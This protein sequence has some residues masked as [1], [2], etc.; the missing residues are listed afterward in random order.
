MGNDVNGAAILWLSG[1]LNA[2]RQGSGL[3][4]AAYKRSE[5]RAVDTV[6]VGNML[7][8]HVG[9]EITRKYDDI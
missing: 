3:Y 5:G 4:R 8:V 7:Q 6:Q 9:N 2:L 1:S